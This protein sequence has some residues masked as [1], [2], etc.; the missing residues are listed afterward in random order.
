MAQLSPTMETALTTADDNGLISQARTGTL[1]ALVRRGL[2]APTTTDTGTRWYLT[3]DGMTHRARLSGTTTPADRPALTAADV[4]VAVD[5]AIGWLGYTA[6]EEARQQPA[7]VVLANEVK[8]TRRVMRRAL[9]NSGPQAAQGAVNQHTA[10][11]EA[12]QAAR[13]LEAATTTQAPAAP[14]WADVRS[15]DPS[16]LKVGDMTITPA[17]GTA[18]HTA[19]DG[20][21][22]GAGIAWEMPLEGTVFTITGIDGDAFT[23]LRADGREMT[24]KV[25]VGARLLRI[26]PQGAQEAPQGAQEAPAGPVTVWATS[27]HGERLT[28][29]RIPNGDPQRVAAF[30]AE[31]ER[32]GAFTDVSTREAV[33]YTVTVL[34][35][36]SRDITAREYLSELDAVRAVESATVYANMAP[37][38]VVPE[39]AWDAYRRGSALREAIQAA[40]TEHA[41]AVGDKDAHGNVILDRVAGW[42]IT[43]GEFC[44]CLARKGRTTLHTSGNLDQARAM[45]RANA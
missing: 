5:K 37:L 20:T 30:I 36:D 28:Y 15:V 23:S 24:Q 10:A 39:P 45:A 7:S 42:V 22:R 19:P 11:M 8:R 38:S 4:A 33:G 25:P 9:T 40:R 12:L 29:A 2:A 27:A 3:Q 44:H 31:A 1:A 26:T 34:D 43:R 35:T 16:E 32:G 14:R 13:A 41:W 18:Y 6:A 21:V 17:V